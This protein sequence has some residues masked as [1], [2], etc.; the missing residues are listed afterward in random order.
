MK[1]S[2]QSINQF[3]TFNNQSINQF[4]QTNQGFLLHSSYT[5]PVLHELVL[6]YL[7]S[8]AYFKLKNKFLNVMKLH[9]PP[10]PLVLISLIW[11][12]QD[13]LGSVLI[14]F[15]LSVTLQSINQ[16]TNLVP[17]VSLESSLES[18]LEISLT[19]SSTIPV[20]P[21]S[22]TRTSVAWLHR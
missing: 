13:L 2:F 16:S 18:T 20:N 8:L 6:S 12:C 19:S 10:P 5:D 4:F 15:R 17:E 9:K 21:Y 7:Q 1:F 11:N 22:R 14:D 3:L